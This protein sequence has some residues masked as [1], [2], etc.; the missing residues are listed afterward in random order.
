MEAEPGTAFVD[1]NSMRIHAGSLLNLGEKQQFGR[2]RN[3]GN[4]IHRVQNRRQGDR[5]G[6][7]GNEKEIHDTEFREEPRQL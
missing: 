4:G 7:V 1:G 5:G 3:R 6:T 2:I